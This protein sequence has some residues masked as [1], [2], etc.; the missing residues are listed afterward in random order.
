MN[1]KETAWVGFLAGVY[2]ILDK[3][4]GYELYDDNT[5]RELFEIWWSEQ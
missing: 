2:V 5:I 1:E 4:G 3:Q